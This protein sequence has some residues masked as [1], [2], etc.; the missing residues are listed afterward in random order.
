MT[1]GLSKTYVEKLKGYGLRFKNNL[2][3]I[4]EFLSK[5]KEQILHLS[6]QYTR[7]GSMHVLQTLESNNLTQNYNDLKAQYDYIF[8]RL[9]TLLRKDT[10]AYVLNAFNSSS[11]THR[12]LVIENQD[13]TQENTNTN[14]LYLK[15]FEIINANNIDK[16]NN[17]ASKMRKIILIARDVDQLDE[18]FREKFQEVK[19]QTSFEDLDENTQ[20]NLLK[21]KVNWQGKYI[22][23]NEIINKK[24]ASKIIDQASLSKLIEEENIQ[25]GNTQAFSSIGY[26]GGEEGYYIPR[27]FYAI[28]SSTADA[29]R[30]ENYF[31]KPKTLG[32]QVIIVA[33][34]AGMGKSTVLTSIAQVMKKESPALWIVRINLNDYAEKGNE[35]S[36]EKID[37]QE[38]E[39]VKAIDFVSKMVVPD[40]SENTNI[41]LQREFFKAGL[42]KLQNTDS[43][44]FKTPKI[45]ILFDGFDEICSDY[46]SKTTN[47]IKALNESKV[48]QIWIPTRVQEKKLGKKLEARVYGLRSL[49]EEQQMDFLMRFWKWN[50][51]FYKDSYNRKRERNKDDILEHLNDINVPNEQFTNTLNILREHN[52]PEQ[53]KKDIDELDFFKHAQ[54]LLDQ[55]NKLI[56]DRVFHLVP[57]KLR[58][59]AQLVWVK[60]LLSGKT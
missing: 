9:R 34:I 52:E 33:D 22:S 60:K 58:K 27:T 57:L 20:D 8:M 40:D 12:L 42:T 43:Q 53:L 35:N 28:L 17:F 54:I 16:K 36:L 44:E 25:I 4:N 56:G 48:I 32:Q 31:K 5:D 30:D 38:Y 15:L 13:K 45:V 10:Q 29:D 49:T 59:L 51:K 41:Q 46:R 47:L 7:L 19:F 21:R 3:S 39:I 2:E 26:V 50:L 37:F 18:N 24:S 14:E 1:S 23:L 11:L 6:T 55:L